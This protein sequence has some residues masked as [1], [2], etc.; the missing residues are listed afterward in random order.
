LA[1]DPHFRLKSSAL[2]AVSL[3]Y[4]PWHV[5]LLLEGPTTARTSAASSLSVTHRPA[6]AS[7]RISGKN[8]SR[9][10][11]E[12]DDVAVDGLLELKHTEVHIRPEAAS[13]IGIA[14]SIDG[15]VGRLSRPPHLRIDSGTL[16]SRLSPDSQ[17]EVERIE[18]KQG[19]IA[20]WGSGHLR[21]DEGHRS[22][23]KLA[24]AT[25]NLDGL[26]DILEPHLLM[27]DQQKGNL[28]MV[29]GLLGQQAKIEL[30]ALNGELFVGPFKVSDLLPLY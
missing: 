24:T 4:M 1:V 22:S 15:F 23:G 13:G 19:S 30:T 16:N 25:N 9:V 18:L 28:R 5:I 29:M 7:V 27:T 6:K 3:A 11:M 10:S 2:Q 17:L 14:A 20:Y 21:I 26:L 8:V 12:L